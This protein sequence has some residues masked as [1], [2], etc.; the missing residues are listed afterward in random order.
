MLSVDPYLQTIIAFAVAFILSVIAGKFIIPALQK[1]HMGQQI[2]TKDGP[3]WHASKQGT[4]TMGGFIFIIAVVI[5]YFVVAFPYYTKGSDKVFSDIPFP[6]G[7]LTGL[8]VALLFGLMGFLDDFVKVVKKRNLGLTA[9]QKII[10]Q[11]I[12]AAA[13]LVFIGIQNGGDTRMLIPFTDI[14]IDFGY[15]YYVIALILIV[16]FTNA[17]NLTDGVDGLAGSVTVPVSL[18]FTV[19][20]LSGSALNQIQTET[21]ILSIALCGA[22]LGFLVYNWHPAKTFM[23]DTGSMFLGGIVVVLA[24]Q[25]KIPLILIVVG[26]IYLVEALSVMIQVTYFKLTHGKRLFKMTPIHHS[27]ELS[28]YSESKICMLFTS[29]TVILVAITCVWILL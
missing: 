26:F 27:F 10:I 24:F 17:V 3:A 28:G 9:I 13:Y 19:A 2:L 8:V 5:A 11:I 25:I 12:I 23:G 22:L 1:L 18:F 21:A 29:V 15:F 7:T 20:A 16:G 6:T 14:W 4:P